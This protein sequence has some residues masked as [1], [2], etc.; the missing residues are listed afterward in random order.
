M[1]KLVGAHI[2]PDVH[3]FIHTE[4]EPD[5]AHIRL[6]RAGRTLDS[7]HL[8]RNEVSAIII[9]KDGEIEDL[10]ISYNLLTNIGRDLWSD[11]LGAKI[12]AGGQGT[13][14]TASSATSLTGT[15]SV[16]T[17]SNQGTPQLGLLGM[18]VY[19]P[20][21]NTATAPVYGNIG[22]N[23]TNVIT[24]DQWW[25]AADGTGTTPAATGSFIL[26]A[27]GPPSPRFMALT[28]DA[29][30][31]NATDTAL[32]SE[33]NANAV[34]RSLAT[35]AHTYG[36]ATMT[37]QK[38]WSPSGTITALHKMGL[39]STSTLTS[40][41]VLMFESVLNA[42]ATVVNGDTLTVTDTITLSG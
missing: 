19:A 10:G 33:N 17:A 24:V 35:Y 16:W 5:G 11:A 36:N 2:I 23:T 13:P 15:G 3:P 42:D 25:N 28:T 22:S 12:P 7:F 39:F 34:T 32:A 18:R 30:A 21:T 14:A 37:L 29:A 31:A 1:S 4:S 6:M 41:G 8:G 27:G 9:H 20:I 40:V 38:Q 26:G